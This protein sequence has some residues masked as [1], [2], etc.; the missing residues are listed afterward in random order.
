MQK[1]WQQKIAKLPNFLRSR[2]G[3]A[4]EMSLFF[5]DLVWH[6]PCK[7]LIVRKLILTSINEN[8]NVNEK[9]RSSKNNG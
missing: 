1:K 9:N 8:K 7:C 4:G 2:K 3:K 5:N 6:E